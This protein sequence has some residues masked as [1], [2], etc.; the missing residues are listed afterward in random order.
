MYLLTE[1]DNLMKKYNSAWLKDSADIK[2][3][4]DS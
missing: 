3:Q 4:F 2:K 1:N